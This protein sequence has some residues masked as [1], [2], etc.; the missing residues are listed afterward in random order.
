MLLAHYSN[1]QT[2]TLFESTDR[3]PEPQGPVQAGSA[4]GMQA[5]GQ[6]AFTLK[7]ASR[8]G[9]NYRATLLSRDGTEVEL[10]WQNGQSV[11]VPGYENF[12][13]SNVQGRQVTLLHPGQDVCINNESA[14]VSCI[15]STQALLSLSNAK[16][17]V[18]NTA[19]QGAGP[20]AA[21]I[22]GNGE[23]I[24]AGPGGVM[25]NA[26]GQQVFR[27]PF[28]GEIEVVEQQLSPE[29]LSARA[30]RQAARRGRLSNFQPERISEA[31]VPPG[32]RL[33][34]TPF[35]DRIVPV[36]E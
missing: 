14:G 21:Q 23:A 27:N 9:D 13:V 32:M 4:P 12:R 7:G 26:N 11:P 1:A 25:I 8:F 17:L 6:P 18:P 34:R 28:S 35:G 29:E 24:T 16:P 3:E 36:R 15:S 10:A 33:V 20:E 22:F 5:G 2:L 19:A 30:E 31:D